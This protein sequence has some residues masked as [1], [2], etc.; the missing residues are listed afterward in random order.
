MGH[1]REKLQ[2]LIDRKD[3][4][5]QELW[6]VV[7]ALRG[8]DNGNDTAKKATTCVIRHTLGFKNEVENDWIPFVVNPD[9]EA[10]VS[11]REYL[12]HTRL[13]EEQ[14]HFYSHVKSAF[15]ALNLEWDKVN[16]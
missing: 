15:V 3:I 14:G 6:S 12:T 7:T 2:E 10:N 13:F 8:P 16:K 5:D 4:N 1:I 11:V 9:E